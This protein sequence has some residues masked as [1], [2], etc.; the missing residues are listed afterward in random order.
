MEPGKV[1]STGA[2]VAQAALC[3]S[4]AHAVSPIPPAK[5]IVVV[6]VEPGQG[7]GSKETHGPTLLLD[8]SKSLH[9]RQPGTLEPQEHHLTFDSVLGPGAT[10]EAEQEMLTQIQP[11]LA[12]VA[13]GYNI[14]L[15]LQGRETEAPRFVPQVLQ[16]LFEEALPL[17]SSGPVLC[18]LS[19]VQISSSGQ[20]RDLLSPCLE[21][22]PVLDVAPLGLV[23]K[24]ASEVEVSDAQAA[25]ELYLKAAVSEGSH[26]LCRACSLL[27][28]TMSCPGPETQ[29]LWRGTLRI[30]QLPGD[31][32][33]PLLRVLAGEAAAEEEVEGSLPWIVSWLLEGNSYSSL[34]LRLDPQGSSSSLL[35][36]ALLGAARKRVQLKEVRPTL[37]NAAE[38]IRARRATLKTLRLGLLG[39]TLTDGGLNQLGRAIWELQVVKAW[40]PRSHV[41]KGARAESMELPEPQVEGKPLN[42]CKQGRHSAQSSEAEIRGFLG[43]GLHQ[44]H[45]LRSSK[46]QV[47]QAPD[48][49]LQ[50][51]LA[52]ARRQRLRE[53]HRIRLQKE[54]KRLEYQEKV[55]CKE[56]KGMVAE[57]ACEEKETQQK[58][59]MVLKLQVEALQAERNMAEQD[60]VALY[61][62]YVQVTRARTCHLLQVFQAWQGL[63]EEKAVATE[64]HH[65]S[66]LAAVLQDTIDLALK[67]QELQ[68]QNQQ[69]EQ[70]A[71]R[72]SHAGVLP[73]EKPGQEYFG[74]TFPCPHS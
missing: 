62:L 56:T 70:S 67:N 51:F 74:A 23:V 58:E 28:L 64:H 35:Q 43:S 4:G 45:L 36:S 3:P 40:A 10:Q 18:T 63:W 12:Y 22:L 27:T 19:L 60:L 34:L 66:L 61:D 55:A 29:Q 71:G 14:A 49:A 57:E 20:T 30:M 32:D 21:D 25:S 5:L 48:V 6:E 72:A 41:P 17:C 73:R 31:P 37:W 1:V 24:D 2:A 42:Y 26:V 50:F 69:L 65:R 68:A 9:L 44:K 52:Q 53:E 39:D 16:M 13:Q 15:L 8:G 11:M 47:L 54:L 46:E 38:E 59:Q 33:C 7:S